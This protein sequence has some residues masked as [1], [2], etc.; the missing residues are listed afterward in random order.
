VKQ[1]NIEKW[2]QAA[3]LKDAPFRQAVHT[4]L[5][6]ISGNEVLQSSMIMKGGVL[7]A[8]GYRSYRFTRDIDFSTPTTLEE[9]DQED[10]KER[11]DESLAYAVERLEY[12]LDCRIQS[13]RQEPAGDGASF[14]TIKTTIGYAYK[15]NSRSHKRL[16]AGNS[17]DI[18]KIDYSLN[19]PVGSIDY[20]SLA[21]GN[22]QVYDIV[23]LVA[24]KFR[25]LLQQGVRKR[26]R[27]QDLYDLYHVFEVARDDFSPEVKT[28]ILK[29]LVVK[30]ETRGL[31]LTHESMSN[32]EII[33]RTREGYKVSLPSMIEGE[34]QPFDEIYPAVEAFYRSLPWE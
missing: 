28:K 10:F 5:L 3:E 15:N 21:D 12:G 2:V 23:E 4:V 33:R 6:A 25:A 7:L 34:L 17:S 16:Q 29:R 20:F 27:A 32:E 26:V 9:F 18:I 8:L 24:E 30:A 1:T 22:I 14:P 31:P 11:L 13:I 19:E